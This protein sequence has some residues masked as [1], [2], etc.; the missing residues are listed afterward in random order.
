LIHSRDSYTE[1]VEK[2]VRV[3]SSF[4][5]ADAAD[6][7]A[8]ASLSPEERLRILIELRDRRQPDASEQRFA[9]VCRIVERER[10]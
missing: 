8:D 7:R 4:A 10:S 2:I 1:A 6:V 9:R 5:D 3:F